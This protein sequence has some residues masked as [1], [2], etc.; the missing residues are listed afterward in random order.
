KIETGTGILSKNSVIKF[1][2]NLDVP[3]NVEATPSDVVL[4]QGDLPDDLSVL[5]DLASII[6][7]ASLKF[8]GWKN[9]TGLAA[10]IILEKSN[11]DKI[12]SGDISTANPSIVLTSEQIRSIATG[13]VKYKILVPKDQSVSLNYNGA[14]NAIPYIAVELKVA[15]EVKLGNGN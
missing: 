13:G 15:T 14:I 5:N 9:T 6:D 4:T 3:F 1:A 7:K 10:E 11:G 8:K 12:L 2:L